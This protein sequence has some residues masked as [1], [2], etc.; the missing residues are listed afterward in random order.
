MF[1]DIEKFDL[2]ICSN[3]IKKN[4]LKEASNLKKLVNFKFMSMK[5]FCDFYFG[6]C[7]SKSLYFLMEEFNLDYDVAL[8][9]LDNIMFDLDDLK[10]YYDY[11]DKLG[12]IYKGNKIN[13][14]KIC[15]IGYDVELYIKKV[16]DKYNTFYYSISTDNYKPTINGFDLMEDE[17]V[18]VAGDICEKLDKHSIDEFY[19]VN[20]PCEYEASVRRIFSLF[21][22]PIN[23]SSSYKIY[24]TETCQKFLKNLR[25]KKDVKLALE[26]L[27][28]ND[29]YNKII[30][31]LNKYAFVSS[32]S[33]VFI[34]I[35]DNELKNASILCDRYKKAINVVTED[36]IT[37]NGFYYLLG[38]NQGRYPKVYSDD[39]Y[40]D[41][42]VKKDKGLFT[43]LDKFK[44]SKKKII[45]YLSKYSNLYISFCLKDNYNVFYPSSLI[46]ELGYDVCYNL[47]KDYIY[48][49]DYNKIKLGKLLDL[50]YK[51]NE[52]SDD[53]K[54]LFNNYEIGYNEYD[55]KFTGINFN[56]LNRK[57]NGKFNL[58]YSNM[59]NYYLCAFRFY[60]ANVL[61]LDFFEK[62]FLTE[63]GS[64]FHYCLSHMYDDDFSLEKRYHGYKFDMDL[65]CKEKFFLKKLY[66]N[67]VF[68]VDTIR[69]QD[70]YSSFDKVMCEKKFTIDKSSKIKINF[71]GIVDKIKYKEHDGKTLAVII[72]YK[73]G[74]VDTKLDNINY[75][76]HMQLPIYV[77]LVKNGM[78]KDIDIVGFY[79]Q[80]IINGV[81]ID[82]TQE[83]MRKK[84][85]LDGYTLD[86]ENLICEFDS[87]YENSNVIKSIKVGKNGF[88]SYAKLVNELGIDKINKLVSSKV[89]EC[90]NSLYEGNFDINPKRIDDKNYGCEFCK[91]RDLCF[92]KE[93][94][95][96]NLK[97]VSFDEIV[98]D[99][100]D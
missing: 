46:E 43:S 27:S 39:D 81:S 20:L 7:D 47:K 1:N 89:D 49:S 5:E 67:L 40:M 97:N 32:V 37:S 82:D 28:L 48:S 79:I 54:V 62:T 16:L 25:E 13:Y 51:F 96:V 18:Y 3:G 84:L 95:F 45:S 31:I 21:H 23:L 66:K 29:V 26:G 93:E 6:Y 41:D 65:S 22:L 19:L 8:E 4:I 77:Y 75:G 44:N 11:L 76:L 17:I 42:E 15:V 63:I 12:F 57:L 50:Y 73:T 55:N 94:D 33:D 100:N 86:N 78:M 71:V 58:S 59:N 60:V 90:I 69:K 99:T 10:I 68:I 88:S 34:S 2:I 52:V 30:D 64:L 38:F 53:L 98:G 9:Y 85:M 56:D 14:D 35:I 80:R 87:S 74:F 91:F 70:D 92:R 72:D 83:D 36:E 24:G 61:K